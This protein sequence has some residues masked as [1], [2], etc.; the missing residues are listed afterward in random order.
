MMESRRIASNA[1]PS[2]GHRDGSV[3]LVAFQ[4][5]LAEQRRHNDRAD[6]TRK[7]T[8]LWCLRHPEEAVRHGIRSQ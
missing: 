5:F 1:F 2:D 7:R 3:S 4:A 8:A 6:D